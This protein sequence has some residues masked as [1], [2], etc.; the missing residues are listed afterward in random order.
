MPAT[1]Q[2]E[3]PHITL[4]YATR[5]HAD[6]AWQGIMNKI[7]PLLAP[8]R[9]NV[10]LTRLLHRLHGGLCEEFCVP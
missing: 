4:Y 3:T 2:C 8:L 6:Q 5:E 9:A 10:V 7:A 1:V